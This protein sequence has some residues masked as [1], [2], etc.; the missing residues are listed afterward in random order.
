MVLC[1]TLA[2][3][4][5]VIVKL[6]GRL[7]CEEMF[8]AINR[9]SG[10]WHLLGAALDLRMLEL[11]QLDAVA[12]AGKD[13]AQN[14]HSRHPGNVTDNAVDLDIHLREGLLHALHQAI[15]ILAQSITQAQVAAHHAHLGFWTKRASQHSEGVEFLQPLA[16]VDVSLAS[17]DVLGMAGVD[18]ANL[19]SVSLQHLKERNPVN[20]GR[21]HGDGLDLASPEPVAQ[22]D[23]IASKHPEAANRIFIPI[24]R[25][26]HP[27]RIGSHIDSGSVEVHLLQQSPLSAALAL[28]FL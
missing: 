15:A 28:D 18:Q 27:M 20:S 14:T 19:K 26:G 5:I 23:Q 1:V 22:S 11:G 25:H 16:V 17:W 8:L 10:P 21:F 7:Q 12:F 24:L 3:E 6:Q 2:L 4:L 13:G 9:L